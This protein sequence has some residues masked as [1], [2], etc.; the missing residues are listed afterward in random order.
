LQTFSVST[1]FQLLLRSIE[2]NGARKS[3]WLL[4]WTPETHI[5]LST[6]E[7]VVGGSSKFWFLCSS[8][9][10]LVQNVHAFCDI[11]A[12][13][14]HGAYNCDRKLQCSRYTIFLVRKPCMQLP[15]PHPFTQY[16]YYCK[17]K[18]YYGVLHM[19]DFKAGHLKCL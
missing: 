7:D 11:H 6:T 13:H 18:S 15:F 4:I 8:V 5:P 10:N 9:T 3:H 19:R 17:H 1:A 2:W 12:L 14:G 16:S